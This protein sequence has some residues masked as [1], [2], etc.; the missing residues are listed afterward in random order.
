MKASLPKWLQWRGDW[1]HYYRRV[2]TRYAH[3]DRR[4][5]VTAAC[6]TDDVGKAVVARDRL[7]ELF[8]DYWRSLARSEDPDAR[9]KHLAAIVRARLEGFTYIPATKLLEGPDEEIIRRLEQLGF[10][11][12]ADERNPGAKATPDEKAA[13]VS[14][15]GMVKDPELTFS[16]LVETYENL[17]KEERRKMSEMQLHK[18]RL[19][20]TRATK[21]IIAALGGD[22]SI[23][24]FSRAD[25][26]EFRDWWYKRVIDEH[27]SVE[28]AN[29]DITH[30]G[31][32]IAL[33]SDRYDLELPRR[34]RALRF[35]SNDRTTR[36][37]FS[38]DHIRDVLLAPRALDGL[39]AG[40][41]GVVLGMINTGARPSELAGLRPED[42][43][44]KAEIPHISI[45]AYPGRVLKTRFSER[46]LPLV[47]PSLEGIRLVLESG[48]VYRDRGGQLSGAVNK[49]LDE[50]NLLET[51]SHVL[52]S[53]RHSFKDRLTSVDAPGLIGSELMGHKFDRP[54]YCQGPTLE[55]KLEWVLKIAI[56]GRPKA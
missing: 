33:V 11:Q 2:P 4:R 56:T 52:Y 16:R 49:F 50:N 19:P 25:A 54:F 23:A 13:T 14:L 47:G 43:H 24:S 12:K 15:L 6:D 38:T 35:V 8:E 30:I 17:T 31:K 3:L 18:W 32:M 5:F 28:S 40:A 10:N 7:N 39:N 27:L 9:R 46:L 29:K 51:P 22:R 34:F 20:L 21:N 42:I 45:R 37:P 26:L 55:K 1:L 44:L 48:G 36:P 53:L 41:R